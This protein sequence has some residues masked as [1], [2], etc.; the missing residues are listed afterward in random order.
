MSKAPMCARAEFLMKRFSSNEPRERR[1]NKGP[2]LVMIKYNTTSSRDLWSQLLP[3]A[4][5]DM[6]QHLPLTHCDLTSTILPHTGPRYALIRAALSL[7]WPCIFKT[8]IAQLN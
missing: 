2:K 4:R 8:R 1:D 3:P 6:C 5:C 7:F